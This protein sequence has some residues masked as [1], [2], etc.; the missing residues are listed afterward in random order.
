MRRSR[1]AVNLQ[2]RAHALPPSSCARNR[3][4]DAMSAHAGE[5]AERTGD[6]RCARCHQK[7]HVAAGHTIPKCPNC[8]NDVFDTRENEPGNKS[9]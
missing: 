1:N 2:E 9:S 8:G 4:D 7:T 5:K 3:K 6:F